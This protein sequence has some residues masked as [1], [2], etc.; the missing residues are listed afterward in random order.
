M[1]KVVLNPL[2]VPFRGSGV[3]DGAPP[4]KKKDKQKPTKGDNMSVNETKAVPKTAQ[5]AAPLTPRN[6]VQN[7]ISETQKK[8]KGKKSFVKRD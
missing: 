8:P 7:G 2:L 6:I 3:K 5:P 4:T 1:N